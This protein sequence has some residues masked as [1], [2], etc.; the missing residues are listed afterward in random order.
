VRG[1]ARR[2]GGRRRNL[3]HET[4]GGVHVL[5]VPTALDDPLRSKESRSVT[6]G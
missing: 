3:V 4:H 6:S 5:Y 2:L 1:L